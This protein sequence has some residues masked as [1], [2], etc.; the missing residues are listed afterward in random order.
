[1]RCRRRPPGRS[2]RPAAPSPSW[3]G[4]AS[5]ERHDSRDAERAGEGVPRPFLSVRRRRFSWR[6]APRRAPPGRWSG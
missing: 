5:A 4:R 3:T 1:R 6:R 2:P